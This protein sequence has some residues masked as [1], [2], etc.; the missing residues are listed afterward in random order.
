M[1]IATDA[2]D[3]DQKI[4]I[5]RHC[6][7]NTADY[8]TSMCHGDIYPTRLLLSLNVQRELFT[9][10]QILGGECRW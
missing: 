6:W 5:S 10:K 7:L 1:V 8:S 4:F 2:L 3:N 9:Q